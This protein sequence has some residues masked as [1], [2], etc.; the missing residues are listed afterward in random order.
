MES[1]FP[2]EMLA[3]ACEG[4]EGAKKKRPSLEEGRVKVASSKLSEKVKGGGA[5]SVSSDSKFSG[6]RLLKGQPRFPVGSGYV[7]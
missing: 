7:R 6:V 1:S 3:T 5:G 2:A 4:K